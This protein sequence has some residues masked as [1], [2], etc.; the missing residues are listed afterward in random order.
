MMVDIQEQIHVK[1]VHNAAELNKIWSCAI[2]V[3]KFA[4]KKNFFSCSSFV[5][6]CGDYKEML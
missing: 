2:I 5:Y 4:T 1:M 6:Q 3:Q